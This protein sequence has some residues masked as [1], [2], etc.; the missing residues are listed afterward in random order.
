MTM[1]ILFIEASIGAAG[2]RLLLSVTLDEVQLDI[3]VAR[4]AFE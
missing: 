3:D 2:L 1:M 4:V